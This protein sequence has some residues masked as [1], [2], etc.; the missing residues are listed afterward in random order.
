MLMLSLI[1][2]NDR[3]SEIIVEKILLTCLF[4]AGGEKKTI[5]WVVQ[6]RRSS[7]IFCE[8][9]RNTCLKKTSAS[10]TAGMRQKL[11]CSSTT[12][13]V[14]HQLY[15]HITINVTDIPLNLTEMMRG[16]C[17]S[18]QRGPLRLY[19]NE[20][21]GKCFVKHSLSDSSVVLG[22]QP[23]WRW[24]LYQRYFPF[25]WLCVITC[26][27]PTAGSLW[28]GWLH[29]LVIGWPVTWNHFI[30]QPHHTG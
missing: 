1:L 8:T 16:S 23:R 15:Q 29:V 6:W 28:E 2:A 21:N 19:M 12:V 9:G 18:R 13:D 14:V 4:F 7:N 5:I 27:P 22:H 24:S 25:C 3:G 20:V 26:H 11:T 17:L 10:N 30:N